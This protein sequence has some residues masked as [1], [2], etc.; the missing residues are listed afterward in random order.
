MIFFL[1][2]AYTFCK[3]IVLT[4]IWMKTMTIHINHNQRTNMMLICK[5]PMSICPLHL[6]EEPL[7]RFFW[8]ETRIFE[9][10]FRMI[11]RTIMIMNQDGKRSVLEITKM[12]G[13]QIPS[14]AVE[15]DLISGSRENFGLIG[16]SKFWRYFLRWNQ[17]WEDW[18]IHKWSHWRLWRHQLLEADSAVSCF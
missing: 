12:L 6:A 5:W 14:N 7:W 17:C 10:Y 3:Y 13:S 18:R 2:H 8:D 9:K 11:A 1:M 4:T 16:F 15:F